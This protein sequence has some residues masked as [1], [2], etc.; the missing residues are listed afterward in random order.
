VVDSSTVQR[1]NRRADRSAGSSARAA[2]RWLLVAA[3]VL[4]GLLAVAGA[5]AD[6]FTGNGAALYEA[7][8]NEPERLQF[9]ALSYHFAYL[10]WA[11]AALF[12]SGLVRRRGSWL[13]NVAGVL[14]LLGISTMPGFILADFYDSSIGQLFG[15]EGALQV[16]ERMGDMWALIAMASTGA[17]GLVL[18]LPVATLA[19]WRAGLLPWWAVAAPTA[20][21]VVGFFVLGPT[22][23]AGVALTAGFVVLAVALAR[24]D[25]DAGD[26]VPAV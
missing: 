23:V 2:R 10:F 11:V 1:E 3:P 7:Y 8:A 20:G 26:A 18:A 6:P 16:E 9:K 15:V 24:M 25:P 19:A 5:A 14:A 21:I 22:V 12:L 17:L 4:A 13:A